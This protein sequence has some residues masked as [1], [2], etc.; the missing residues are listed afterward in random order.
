MAVFEQLPVD[1]QR[2]V[3]DVVIHPYRSYGHAVR[4]RRGA[5]GEEGVTNAL[6][7]LK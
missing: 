4:R 2:Q 3:E 1:I 5:V 7:L 6:C